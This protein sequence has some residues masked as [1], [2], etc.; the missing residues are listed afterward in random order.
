MP[1]TDRKSYLTP[2]QLAER[3]GWHPESVRRK[4]REGKIAA[5]TVF[6]RRLIALAEVERIEVEGK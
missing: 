2:T 5:V 1:P 3:W 4:I 6:R